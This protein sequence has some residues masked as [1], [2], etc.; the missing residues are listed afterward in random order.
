MNLKH[1]IGKLT[2]AGNGGSYHGYFAKGQR[3]GEGIFHY[4]NSDRYSGA[5][6][7]GKKHG[8]GT[9][10]IDNENIKVRISF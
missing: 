9:Y 1:G 6:K 3:S 7:Y 8:Y 2:Y 4:A 5:W 10:I